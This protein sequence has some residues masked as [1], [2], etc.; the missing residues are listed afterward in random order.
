MD[1]DD[2]TVY[3]KVIEINRFLLENENQPSCLGDGIANRNF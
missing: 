1:I 3:H 2:K